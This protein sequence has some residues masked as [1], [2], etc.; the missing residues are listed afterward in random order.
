MAMLHLLAGV[1]TDP[2]AQLAVVTVDHAL[3]PGSAEEAALVAEVCA[4]LGIAHQTLVWTHDTIPGNLQDQARRA[5]YGLIC[6][7]ARDRGIARVA[8]AHT[9]DDQAETFLMG[10]SRQ[11]GLDGLTG[12]RA[13]WQQDGVTFER[14][15]LDLGR[16]ELRAFLTRRGLVWREDPSNENA[17]FLRVRARRALADLAPLGITA[18]TLAG[19][20]AHLARTQGLIRAATAEAFA[21]IGTE[22]AGAVTLS[23]PGFAALDGE[24]ARHLLVTILRW[25]TG[26]AH[27]PRAEGV[28]RLLAAI[29]RGQEATLAGCRIRIGADRIRIMRE[30]RAVAGQVTVVQTP[31]AGGWLWDGRWRLSGPFAPG[32]SLRALGAQGLRACPDWRDTGLSRDL[33][34][35]TPA[36][37]SEDRLIAA[38]V[39]SPEASRSAGWGAAITPGLA[40]FILS[41]SFVLSH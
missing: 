24:L 19:T 1:A 32:L 22:A 31:A 35:V 8:L 17:R 10:L 20:I 33:L 23:R 9:R 26:S 14:P 37:W 16:A 39:A 25:M 7:W 27:P 3:R 36:V 18:E 11:A 29:A 2:G 38:P 4:G 5:R 13:G 12:M 6:G 40:R 28:A 41:P 34:M 30:G 21:R 15:F